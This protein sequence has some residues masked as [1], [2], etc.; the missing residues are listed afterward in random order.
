M[1]GS[2]RARR[3][4]TSSFVLVVVIFFAVH[5]MDLYPWNQRFFDFWAYWST[6]FGLDYAAARPG[7]SGAYLYSPAFAHLISPLTALPLPWFGAVWTPTILIVIAPLIDWG[8]DAPAGKWV[9]ATGMSAAGVA[10]ALHRLCRRSRRAGL[11][12]RREL[13]DAVAAMIVPGRPI[14]SRVRGRVPDRAR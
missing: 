10:G 5:V 11:V 13:G 7:E 12:L 3:L 8:A 2:P 14:R 6:R 9:R 1:P 4:A